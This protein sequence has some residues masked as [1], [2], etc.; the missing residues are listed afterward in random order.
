MELVDT[1]AHLMSGQLRSE[2]ADLLQ[3]AREADVTRI[4]TIGTDT[5]DSRGNTELAAAHPEIYATVG[6]HPTSVHEVGK[7]W[8][9]II[10]ELSGREKVTAIGEIGLDYYHPPQDGSEESVWRAK[11]AQFFQAQL[12]L[13]VELK[14][15]VVIHQR[16]CAED[17]LAMIRPYSGK[18]AG[19]VFHCYVGNKEAA[20]ELLDLGFHLSFT[21][22]TT[23]KNAAEVAE[24]A[25][26]VPL[27]RCMVETD[28]P[29][30]APV[31]RRGKRNEPSY[32]R[33]VAAFIAQQRGITLEEFAAA[34]TNTA[35]D[36]FGLAPTKS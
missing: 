2:T 6:I 11:Q 7:D 14:L 20:R 34:T 26:Y 21:G 13:A 32:V 19:A 17:V 36:F 23:Y 12:D 22:V 29:Y 31:P 10:R 30:L 33:H 24:T 1:H 9:Q 5:E 35:I 18:L 27:D 15:P 25:A 4:I 3:R 28:S 8:L 16:E